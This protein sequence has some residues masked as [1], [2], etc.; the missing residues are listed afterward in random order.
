[1][2]AMTQTTNAW[3]DTKYKYMEAQNTNV[4]T[5]TSHRK[6]VWDEQCQSTSTYVIPYILCFFLSLDILARQL[7]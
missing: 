4:W 1:M 7:G 5:D 2:Y 3:N 6:N